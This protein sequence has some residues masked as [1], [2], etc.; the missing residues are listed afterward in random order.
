MIEA[1]AKYY[2]VAKN[3]TTLLLKRLAEAV[4]V[5]IPPKEDLLILLMQQWLAA[6][7]CVLS[8]VLLLATILAGNLPNKAFW[9]SNSD[10][11]NSGNTCCG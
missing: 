3:V 8:L 10:P 5:H 9:E 11:Y 1:G 7:S 6:A 2:K 4:P